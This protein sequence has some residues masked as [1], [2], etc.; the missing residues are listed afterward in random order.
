[1]LFCF[2]VI[3]KK[4]VSNDESRRVIFVAFLDFHIQFD[5][6]NEE[7]NYVFRRFLTNFVALDLIVFEVFLFVMGYIKIT[8]AGSSGCS[9]HVNDSFVTAI[10][11]VFG[12]L[13]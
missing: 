9:L 1:M 2:E 13:R 5:G 4:V 10:D 6:L 11:I 7:I 8:A 12:D 3:D